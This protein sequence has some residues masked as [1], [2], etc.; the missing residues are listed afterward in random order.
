[1]GITKVHGLAVLVTAGITGAIWYHPPVS[2]ASAQEATASSTEG[3]ADMTNMN[4][5]F[6]QLPRQTDLT[7]TSP[8]LP[9]ILYPQPLLTKPQW[10]D[11]LVLTPWL[12]P[13]V[14]E[15]TF[16]RE[17]LN[18]QYVQKTLVTGVVTFAV[19]SIS[20]VQDLTLCC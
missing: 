5:S 15:G 4:Q 1:M 17:I 19:K 9:R 7:E 14:W 8:M 10:R 3:T 6:C 20:S 2:P 12:A 11:V 16:N 13:V 18:A